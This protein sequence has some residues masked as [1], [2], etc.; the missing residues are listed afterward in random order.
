MIR[1]LRALLPRPRDVED[2]RCR[3]LGAASDQ[4]VLHR[5]REA[6]RRPA[7]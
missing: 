7:G 3:R 6:G 1:R 5:L 2:V 4:T